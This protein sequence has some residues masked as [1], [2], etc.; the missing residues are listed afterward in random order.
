MGIREE[1]ICCLTRLHVYLQHECSKQLKCFKQTALSS[2]FSFMPALS[3]ET[4]KWQVDEVAMVTNSAC[5]LVRSCSSS[6][7]SIAIPND[8]VL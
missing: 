6:Y 8:S 4:K 1:F 5:I 3:L 2:N 7:F